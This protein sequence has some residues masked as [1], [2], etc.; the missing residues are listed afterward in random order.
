MHANFS[1]SFINVSGRTLL[2]H[3]MG[4]IQKKI[5]TDKRLKKQTVGWDD[6]NFLKTTS[7]FNMKIW[8][9]TNHITQKCCEIN[10][11]LIIHTGN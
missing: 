7:A 2:F 3:F 8:I 4:N 1:E 6:T 9:I 11:V 10:I 5:R